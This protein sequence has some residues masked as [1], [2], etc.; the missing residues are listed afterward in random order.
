MSQTLQEQS[1]RTEAETVVNWRLVSLAGVLL[2]AC[3][4]T[5]TVTLAW[6]KNQGDAEEPVASTAVTQKAR[7][8]ADMPLEPARAEIGRSVPAR[9]EEMVERLTVVHVP[10]PR[11]V[12]QPATPA[13]QETTQDTP[14][15]VTDERPTY[16]RQSS[17]S[18]A[19]LL[20]SL[21]T[22]VRELDVGIPTAKEM[23][24]LARADESTN[25]ATMPQGKTGKPKA[26]VSRH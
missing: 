9:P 22:N 12:P 26:D 15:R 13:P 3:L 1:Q 21:Q 10:A 20:H 11:P 19:T 2:A 23:L 8:F 7:K 17:H 16:P 18:E 6:L 4:A 5:L 14:P 25:A 24:A